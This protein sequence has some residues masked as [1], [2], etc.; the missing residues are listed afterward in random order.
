M[1]S[2]DNLNRA[3]DDLQQRHNVARSH[4]QRDEYYRG[5]R[6]GISTAVEILIQALQ[7]DRI[8]T[9]QQRADIKSRFSDD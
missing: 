9:P 4:G 2:N 3:I 7:D 5:F 8:I 1:L 6:W